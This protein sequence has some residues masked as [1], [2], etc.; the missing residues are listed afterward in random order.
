[1]IKIFFFKCHIIGI[2]FVRFGWIIY[3]KI[4]FIHPIIILSWYLNDNKCLITQI[5]Y[6][7]FGST[8]LGNGQKFNVP[9]FD[10]YILYFSFFIGSLLNFFKI[11]IYS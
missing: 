3:P 9:V 7:I 11:L 4:L 1:M 10:R 5:E 2:Y 8:F 6:K